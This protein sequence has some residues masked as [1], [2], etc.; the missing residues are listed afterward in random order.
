MMAG[1]IDRNINI[2]IFV[3]APVEQFKIIFSLEISWRMDASESKY[4]W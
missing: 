2:T 4:K 1:A 3:Y